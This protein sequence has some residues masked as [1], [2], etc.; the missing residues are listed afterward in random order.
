MHRPFGALHGSLANLLLWYRP[1]A[2]CFLPPATTPAVSIAEPTIVVRLQVATTFEPIRDSRRVWFG[3]RM[4][5][6]CGC[7]S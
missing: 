6:S 3:F 4:P 7:V 1:F 2:P 5:E